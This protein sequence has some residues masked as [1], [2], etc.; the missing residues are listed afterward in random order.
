MR[1]AILLLLT[2]FVFSIGFSDAISDFIT[3]NLNF[4]VAAFVFVLL[5]GVSIGGAGIWVE[6]KTQV[7]VIALGISALVSVLVLLNSNLSELIYSVIT[8]SPIFLIAFIL[9]ALVLIIFVAPKEKVWMK[10]LAGAILIAAGIGLLIMSGGLSG[11]SGIFTGGT[12]AGIASTSPLLYLALIGVIGLVVVIGV[13]AKKLEGGSLLGGAGGAGAGSPKDLA[14]RLKQGAVLVKTGQP[15]TKI[16]GRIVEYNRKIGKL[17]AASPSIVSSN[18]KYEIMMTCDGLTTPT[19][20]RLTLTN[21]KGEYEAILAD[22]TNSF[23][24]TLGNLGNTW[25]TLTNIQLYFEKNKEQYFQ[26]GEK[27]N[28]Q[29]GD[30]LQIDLAYLPKVGAIIKGR[31]VEFSNNKKILASKI[32]QR[33]EMKLVGTDSNGIPMTSFMWKGEAIESFFNGDFV[34]ML[35]KS[36]NYPITDAIVYAV[37]NN[38]EFYMTDEN[39]ENPYGKNQPFNVDKNK[40]YERIVV[41]VDYAFNYLNVKVNTAG[42]PVSG[43]KVTLVEEANHSIDVDPSNNWGLK[44]TDKY[45]MCNFKVPDNEKRKMVFKIESASI[46]GSPIYKGGDEI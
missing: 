15:I 19:P 32:L 34:I 39:G 26:V 31:V 6:D 1:K 42:N 33:F 9:V 5:F 27:F 10:W 20:I 41:P 2:L 17:E 8:Y 45:G 12:S 28:L 38:R 37:R 18:L 30:Q 35:P 44:T 40:R 22:K 36:M 11:A 21:S 43:A 29:I 25:T 4:V 14:Q 24:Q 46:P 13:I 7:I 23:V 16:F 3:R